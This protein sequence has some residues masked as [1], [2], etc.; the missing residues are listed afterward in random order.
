MMPRDLSQGQYWTYPRP[1]RAIEPGDAYRSLC[2]PL[3]SV[4]RFHQTQD[5]AKSAKWLV[6][7]KRA[8]E[9]SSR[10]LK[11]EEVNEGETGRKTGE[12]FSRRLIHP[13]GLRNSP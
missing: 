8:T 6:E 1:F 2:H 12:Y 13:V 5:A 10:A 11:T 4:F 3:G 7:A 9:I